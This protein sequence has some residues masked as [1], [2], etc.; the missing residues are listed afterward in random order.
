MLNIWLLIL[1]SLSVPLWFFSL[2]TFKLFAQG[3]LAFCSRL[4]RKLAILYEP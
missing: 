3:L 2:A 1:L 4:R